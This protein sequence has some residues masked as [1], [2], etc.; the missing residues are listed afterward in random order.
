MEANLEI[1]E[2]SKQTG[3]HWRQTL[4]KLYVAGSKQSPKANCGSPEAKYVTGS[5]LCHQ[6][7]KGVDQRQTYKWQMITI[8]ELWLKTI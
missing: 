8:S 6:N 5:E 3:S 2:W 1:T 7:S 4:A